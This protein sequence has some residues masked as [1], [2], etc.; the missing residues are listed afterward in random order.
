M[1]VSYLLLSINY[2]YFFQLQFLGF[3]YLAFRM[4]VCNVTDKLHILTGNTS[5]KN[6]LNEIQVLTCIKLLNIST[7]GRHS[8]GV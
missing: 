1:K 8:E 3:S 2:T 4:L 5:I 7:P 6:T